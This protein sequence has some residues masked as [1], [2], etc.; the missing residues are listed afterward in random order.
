MNFF[1]NLAVL[2]VIL[3]LSACAQV[4]SPG[5][6]LKDSKPPRVLRYLPD[7]ASTNIKPK[8]IIIVFDEYFNLKDI[9][10]QLI[11]SPPLNKTPDIKV[12]EKTLLITFSKEDTLKANTTYVFSFGNAIQDN[13]ENNAKE[14]F[15]YVFSTGNF[16]DSLLVRG[17]VENAFDHKSEKNSLVMLYRN[18]TDSSI[19]KSKPDYFTKTRDDGSFEITNVHEGKYKIIA[20]KDANA[21]YKYD[22]NEEKIAFIDTLVMVPS[23]KNIVLELFQE[24]PKKF[25][26]K[27]YI[28]TNYGRIDFYF[29]KGSDS[30]EIKPINWV[31]NKENVIY[32]YSANK[33]T[34]TYW[35]RNIEK[36]SLVLQVN[37]GSKVLDTIEIKLIKKEA[38]LKNEKNQ[39]KFSLLKSPDNNMSFDLGRKVNLKFSTPISQHNNGIQLIEDSTLFQLKD[40]YIELFENKAHITDYYLGIVKSTKEG[41]PDLSNVRAFTNWKPNTSYHLFIPPATFTDFFGLTNDSINIHFKTR[42]EAEYGTLKL[43]LNI[44]KTEQNY[45]VQLLDENE[46]VLREQSVKSSKTMLFEYLT[47]SKYKLKIIYDSNNN[48]KWDRGNFSTQQ[49]PE[50]VIYNS[51][52]ITIRANWDLELKWDVK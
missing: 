20:L 8:S 52:L 15:K 38:A 2:V 26:F 51:E 22:G 12:K 21:N 4:V 30:I 32:D 47:P 11:I 14:N 23:S 44:P 45:S 18:Y 6:G 25:Q 28:Y 7:S 39:L 50:K 46:N 10:N 42:E 33:D 36:D 1:R 40:A 35:F 34:L 24:P 29:N 37:N 43:Q 41:N 13:N 16:I 49:Q 48:E 3:L 17:K 9:T 31:F 19:Y 5:G 27:K